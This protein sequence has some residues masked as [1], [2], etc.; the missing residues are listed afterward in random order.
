[1]NEDHFLT[2]PALCFNLLH[3]P[4]LNHP[5]VQREKPFGVWVSFLGRG[6]GLQCCP[7]PSLE[8]MV[9]SGPIVTIEPSMEQRR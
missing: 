8:T 5:A 7:P 9:L 3:F 6:V 2:L 4:A 1:M